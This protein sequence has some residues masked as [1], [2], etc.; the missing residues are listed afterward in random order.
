MEYPPLILFYVKDKLKNTIQNNR[1]KFA[2]KSALTIGKFT[3]TG[4]LNG[5][6]QG[7]ATPFLIPFFVVVYKLSETKIA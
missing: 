1:N 5:L 6:S 4:I 3:L 7:L 2:L